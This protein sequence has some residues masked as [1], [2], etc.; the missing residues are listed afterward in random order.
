V[1]QINKEKLE[2]ICS[3]IPNEFGDYT[4]K[5]CDHFLAIV[6]NSNKLEFELQRS[7]L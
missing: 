2:D 3:F 7:L 5:I 6:A 1:K 4:E